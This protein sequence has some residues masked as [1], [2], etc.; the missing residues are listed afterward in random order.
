MT[1]ENGKCLLAEKG[2]VNIMQGIFSVFKPWVYQIDIPQSEFQIPRN[3]TFELH[4]LDHAQCV[5]RAQSLHLKYQQTPSSY[6]PPFLS[7]LLLLLLPSPSLS[8]LLFFF[9]PIPHQV[10]DISSILG[11]AIRRTHNG[12]SVSYLLQNIPLQ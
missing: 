12:E 5:L 1:M 7:S 2:C 4:C 6:P 3:Q 9:L 8:N 11:E 10:I